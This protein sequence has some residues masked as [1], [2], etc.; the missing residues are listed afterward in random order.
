MKNFTKTE[1]Q[2]KEEAKTAV[3]AFT[4]NGRNFLSMRLTGSFRWPNRFTT[5]TINGLE[6]LLWPRTN[7]DRPGLIIKCSGDGKEEAKFA[8]R[9]LSG[10]TWESGQPFE[11]EGFWLCGNRVNPCFREKESPHN[12]FAHESYLDEY[13]YIPLPTE[14]KSQIALALYREALSLNN[15]SYKFL[16]FAKILNVKFNA[17]NDQIRWINDNL[18]LINDH[19]AKDRIAASQR[20]L[21]CSSRWKAFL[22]ASP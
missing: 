16:S 14:E 13:D 11:H 22:G 17:P 10:L 21:P 18:S 19:R 1:A 9:L 5:L 8:M 7:W 4:K 6:I 3:E 12:P 15:D 20:P 2:A